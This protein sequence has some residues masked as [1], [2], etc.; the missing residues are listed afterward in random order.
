MAKN[1]LPGQA[2]TVS[3]PLGPGV[4]ERAVRFETSTDQ[5]AG[6]LICCD[7]KS[8]RA[9]LFIHGFGGVRSGPHNLLTYLARALATSG[10][11]SLRFDLSG[12]GES[13]GDPEAV[14]LGG[15][16]EDALSA[17]ALLKSETN[18]RKITVIGICS[19]G[20]VGIGILDR[21]PRP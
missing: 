9:V 6:N 14:T 17:A 13:S 11:P 19:G 4:S 5:L 20:N 16:A 15:M 2:E 21:R 10:I 8:D 12:R 3:I 18:A 1:L 7:G